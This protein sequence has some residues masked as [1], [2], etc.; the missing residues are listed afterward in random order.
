MLINIITCLQTLHYGRGVGS[1]IKKSDRVMTTF[2]QSSCCELNC[3]LNS[4]FP[5]VK[6]LIKLLK[7]V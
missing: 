2:D 1:K 7:Y 6:Y 4:L 5:S 3:D